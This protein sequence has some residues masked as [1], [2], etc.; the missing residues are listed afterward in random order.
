MSLSTSFNDK[1]IR[2]IKKIAFY[3]PIEQNI[4]NQN[5]RSLHF[6]SAAEYDSRQHRNIDW[7]RN[8]NVLPADAVK[9]RPDNR[10]NG[11]CCCT[12]GPAAALDG[13]VVN[14]QRK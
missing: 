5:N 7:L 4:N 3:K 8:Q 1:N 6:N 12:G 11:G 14:G 9:W 2:K 10:L 13:V